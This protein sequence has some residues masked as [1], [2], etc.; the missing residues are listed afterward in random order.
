MMFAK[1]VLRALFRARIGIVT[2]VLV[3]ALAVVFGIVMVNSGNQFAVSYRDSV[4]ANA[5]NTPILIAYN[6]GG[7]LQAALLDFGSNLFL[8]AVPQTLGGIVVV[9][10][11]PVAAYRGWIGGIVSIDG[12][13]NSRLVNP[14]Q[15]N[16]YLSILILQ[17]IPYSLAGGAGVNLGLA[18]FRPKPYYSGD[19]WLG[20]PKEAVLDVLRIYVLVLPLFLVASLIE[21]LT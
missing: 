18:Y 20:M 11:Y 9:L 8:G 21:F 13:H 16:Y 6:R 10:P 7:R 2:M 19:K 4:V 17:L 5:Q 14:A 15:A 3:Y 1:S 12:S